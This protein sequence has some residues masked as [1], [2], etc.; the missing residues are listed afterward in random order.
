MAVV[1]VNA[2]IPSFRAGDYGEQGRYTEADIQELVDTFAPKAFGVPIVVGHPKVNSPAWGW[3]DGA[4]RAGDVLELHVS[5]VDADFAAAVGE[6]KFDRVSVKFRRRPSDQKLQLIHLGFLG[7]WPPGVDTLGRVQF[8]LGQTQFEEGFEVAFSDGDDTQGAA[9]GGLTQQFQ[10]AGAARKGRTMDEEE[11]KLF[12]ADTE[13]RFAEE[14]RAREAA[15]AKATAAEQRTQQ[16][17]AEL[18]QTKSRQALRETESY[19][20]GLVAAKKLPPALKPGLATFLFSLS[21]TTEFEFAAEDGKPAKATPRQFA[22]DF[23]GRVAALGQ[24]E[25][26]FSA[27]A[28]KDSD[29]G[30]TGTSAAGRH[31]VP[32][33]KGSEVAEAEFALIAKAEAYA[34]EHKC[35]VEHALYVVSK[36]G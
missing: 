33:V 8:G 27:T 30:S 24:F 6:R 17:A 19:V 20:D 25:R 5:E 18:A 10:Q 23:L 34:A 12:K 3:L 4:R 35:S 29:P 26:L 16:F 14:K 31:A 36:G 9:L 28:G 21:G 1:K 2:W 7:A 11:F 32:T 13:A 15:E 22:E